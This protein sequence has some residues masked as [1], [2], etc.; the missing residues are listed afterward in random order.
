LNWCS[1]SHLSLFSPHALVL[2]SNTK[3]VLPKN[4]EARMALGDG[5]DGLV[6]MILDIQD[7]EM[8]EL[9]ELFALNI[10]NNQLGQVTEAVSVDEQNALT[11]M[12]TNRAPPDEQHASAPAQS[13]L[14]TKTTRGGSQVNVTPTVAAGATHFYIALLL[15][16]HYKLLPGTFAGTNEG[17][18]RM[19]DMKVEKRKIFSTLTHMMIKELLQ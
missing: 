4:F 13:P 14:V 11:F 18:A 16:F 10:N 12:Q 19:A 2:A 8:P 15:E 1:N 9:D 5:Q 6:A 3:E 17:A 7:V